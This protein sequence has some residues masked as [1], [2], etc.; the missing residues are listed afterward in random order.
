MRPIDIAWDLLKAAGR[1]SPIGG[2]ATK[3][4]FSHGPGPRGFPGSPRASERVD[5]PREGPP[6]ATTGPVKPTGTAD[7]GFMNINEGQDVSGR[8]AEE[9]AMWSALK[10]RTQAAAQRH[11][12]SAINNEQMINDALSADDFTYD[13]H[14]DDE[15]E[16]AMPDEE[17]EYLTHQME[18]YPA[19]YGI[20]PR[21]GWRQTPVHPPVHRG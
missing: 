20:Q 18:N 15:F 3:D 7:T 2:G 13:L 16:G 8:A 1:G 17:K 10:D 9:E 12:S 4:S 11:S 21:I 14:H 19:D 6:M 5:R